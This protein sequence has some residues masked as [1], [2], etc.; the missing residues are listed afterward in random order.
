[1]EY[2]KE[3]FKLLIK[4]F[5]ESELPKIK[6]RDLKLPEKTNKI[7]AVF[8]PR[9]VGKTYYFYQL[10][11]AL[12]SKISKERIIYINFEDDRLFPLELKDLDN[13]I[14]AYFELY[15]EN[16]N[17]LVYCFFDEIQNIKNWELFVRRIYDKEKVKIFITGSSSKL[18]SQEIATS[19]RG[20]TLSYQL[21]P[22]SFQEF[23]RFKGIKLEKNFFYSSQRF[24]IKKMFEEYLIFGG[25]PE[26]VLEA[27]N[28][29]RSV[30]KNYYDL[31]IYR[32]L[33]ERFSIR[34]I[35][36]LKSLMKY[37]L[38][39]ISNLFSVN[40][41]YR[42]IEKHLRPS[43]ETLFEYLSFL[44][45]IGLLFLIPIYSPSLKVQQVNPKKIYVIDNGIRNT[46]SFNFSQDYGRLL[47]NLV[48]VELKRQNKEVY[49]HKGNYECDFI[50]K[51]YL[52][53]EQAIQVT[54]KLNKENETRELNGLIEAIQKYKL[55]QGLILTRDQE[56]EIIKTVDRKKIK[57]E[58]LPIW[59]WLLK[60]A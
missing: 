44:E 39:N 12:R 32:D 60:S 48:F 50:V 58:I 11:Q 57:I 46:V 33:V 38:T 9:R 51:G 31:T 34:N 19:L 16:K 42:S 18:L 20:R 21:F 7:I 28:L 27:K 35:S 43:R 3:I 53:I 22:L 13:L 47:E 36:F 14:E 29:K 56:S 24:Y 40:T 17:K 10:I 1:M 59:K 15:P 54:D 30:L 26:V 8:G 45:E 52:K 23:L 41:Y 6:A 55:K 37:C 25:F 4:E 5:Q 2:K 49:Y